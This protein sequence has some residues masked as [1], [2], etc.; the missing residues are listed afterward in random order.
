[1]VH[2]CL[3]YYYLMLRLAFSLFQSKLVKSKTDFLKRGASLIKSFTKMTEDERKELIKQVSKISLHKW[4]S[5][6]KRTEIK[7]TVYLIGIWSKTTS[8]RQTEGEQWKNWKTEQRAW[9]TSEGSQCRYF[10]HGR[11]RKCTQ[12]KGNENIPISC[13]TSLQGR[14]SCSSSFQIS[15][16]TILQ[17]RQWSRRRVRNQNINSFRAFTD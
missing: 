6:N 2:M 17:A 13:R 14:F 9:Q 1:M 16:V 3:L 10:A 11:R 8:S 5:S 7:W 15:R 4:Q 12:R